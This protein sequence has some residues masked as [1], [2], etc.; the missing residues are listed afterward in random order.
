MS[1]K[2]GKENKNFKMVFNCGKNVMVGETPEAH[3][4]HRIYGCRKN[5]TFLRGYFAFVKK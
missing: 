2:G 1:P 3:P 4:F 5:S